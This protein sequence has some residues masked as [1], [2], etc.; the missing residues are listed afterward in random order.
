M[1]LSAPSTLVIRPIDKT[2]AFTQYATADTFESGAAVAYNL[3][4]GLVEPLASATTYPNSVFVG[5]C[6]KKLTTSNNGTKRV[7]VNTSGGLVRIAVSGATTAAIA[8]NKTV[9]CSS[10]DIDS[11]ATITD[12][13]SLHPIGKVIR[14][15]SSTTCDVMLF[16]ARESFGKALAGGG[17]LYN[18]IAAS[19]AV[20]NT[21]SET[22]FDTKYTIPA[23]I[24]QVGDK[25]RV[26]FGGTAT[27]TNSTNTLTIKGEF[28][29]TEVITS[30]SVDAANSDIWVGE[31]EVTIRSIGA[32]GTAAYVASVRG[33]DAGSTADVDR[34]N[35]GTI[36]SLDTTGTIVCQSTATWSVANAGNSCRQDFFSVELI[37][38]D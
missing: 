6:D 35:A 2:F 36:S 8:S 34:H 28:G 14:W 11:D 26:R 22:A 18:A 12:T 17:M 31:Y 3:A 9:F 15:I 27:A 33:P 30:A 5:I 20:T 4:T 24:L 37:R 19:T 10:D 1:A 38:K 23:N 21:A 29:S 32:S 13:G 16:S 25:L 7:S